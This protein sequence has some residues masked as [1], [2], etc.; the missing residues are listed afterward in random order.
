[1]SSQH[2][3]LVG[4][5]GPAAHSLPGISQDI[6]AW[7]ALVP[8]LAGPHAQLSTVCGADA[9][10]TGIT[11]AV[12]RAAAE[13][14]PTDRVTLVVL[15]HGVSG[16][17]GRSAL[18]SLDG[19][20]VVLAELLAELPD[21]ARVTAFFE[22]CGQPGPRL[23]R[24]MPSSQAV[25]H[26]A[27]RL[28]QLAEQRVIDGRWRGAWS[29]AMARVL[30]QAAGRDALGQEV[31]ELDHATLAARVGRLLEALGLEQ[32]PTVTGPAAR[33]VERVDG[34]LREQVVASP[35]LAMQLPAGCTGLLVRGNTPWMSVQAAADGTFTARLRTGKRVRDLPSQLQL[36][37][38]DPTAL[39]LAQLGG[40][41]LTTPSSLF[42][43]AGNVQVGGGRLFQSSQ[44][45]FVLAIH[46][47]FERLTW[48]A[49]PG[50][51]SGGHLKTALPDDMTHIQ[52]AP[53][54]PAGG[55]MRAID[56]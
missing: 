26:R 47:D 10:A 56:K 41:T 52:S 17:A 34:G 4:A 32:S 33:L 22:L 51:V 15:G 50:L 12:R 14:G 46:R 44:R 49:A 18:L 19:H 16:P 1:M 53:S 39:E 42:L 40:A 48:W 43:P 7:R 45:M 30:E 31:V 29:Y 36:E 13:V 9:T 11:Q 23:L 54:P 3:I 2:V 38:R 25:I 8:L 55:W 37:W 6:A 20:P 5:C 21:P 24:P 27:C 35:R 28:D